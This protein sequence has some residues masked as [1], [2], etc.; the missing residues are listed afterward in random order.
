MCVHPPTP[1]QIAWVIQKL[2]EH[3]RHGG[4]LRA[5]VCKR[6]G[7]ETDRWAYS[8]LRDAGGVELCRILNASRRKKEEE[9]EL[10]R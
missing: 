8:Q 7:L 2:L 9:I 6:M 10:S 4:C 1:A 3:R 5:L